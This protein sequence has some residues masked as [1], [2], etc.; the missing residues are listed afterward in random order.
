MTL[1]ILVLALAALLISHAGLAGVADPWTETGRYE[2][3]YKAD[4]FKIP[5]EANQKVRV[6]V[7]LPAETAAQKIIGQ[8]ID[9]PYPYRI[10]EDSLGNRFLYMEWDK[11]SIYEPRLTMRFVIERD[12]FSGVGTEAAKAG[13]PLDP[14]RY[15]K[16]QKLIPLDG[17]IEKIAV[18]ASRDKSTDADKIRAFYDY[19]LANMKYSKEGEGWGKGDAIWACTSKYGNCTDFHSLFIGMSRSQKI[20]AR[21]VIGFPIPADKEMSVVPGYHCWSE[22]Y[23]SKVGWRPLDASEAWKSG[24]TDEYFGKIPSDRIEFTVGRDLTLEP[25]QDGEPVNYL[26]Y[27]YV[28]VDGN[29]VEDIPVFFRFRDFPDLAAKH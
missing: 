29:P 8:V 28:E 10:T 1:R 13:T 6:W 27:P 19:V 12:P 23:D 21:F 9:A 18:Q 17:V 7:P 22:V 2:F 5:S 25:P 4:L 16:P 15:L 11:P 20:P 3:E 26:I 24:L 14:K